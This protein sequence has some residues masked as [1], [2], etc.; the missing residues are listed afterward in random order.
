MLVLCL[1]IYKGKVH[2]EGIK[3]N[4]GIAA[5]N[6]NLSIRWECVTNFMPWPLYPQR[7]NPPYPWNRKLG[8]PQS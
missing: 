2:L 5:L 8:G 1:G 3:G 7:K 4:I 6:F